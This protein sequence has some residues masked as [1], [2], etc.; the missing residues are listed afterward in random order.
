MLLKSTTPSQYYPSHT[1]GSI[2]YVYKMSKKNP[3]NRAGRN[4]WNISKLLFL[5]TD[6]AGIV[7]V[8]E[9]QQTDMYQ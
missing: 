2:V 3:E 7:R 8:S 4:I 5:S 6:E 1:I 9:V